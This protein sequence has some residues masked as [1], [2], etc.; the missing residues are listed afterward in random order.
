MLA[1]G[2]HCG[3]AAAGKR[4]LVLALA[5][6]KT[7]RWSQ[8]SGQST[9][10]ARTGCREQTTL[11]RTF[12][13]D[14]LV[15]QGL[16]KAE[17]MRIDVIGPISSAPRETARHGDQ[18][19]SCNLPNSLFSQGTQLSHDTRLDLTD[20]WSTSHVR[21]AEHLHIHSDGARLN[22]PLSWLCQ[23]R[24]VLAIYLRKQKRA[25][26]SRHS[27]VLSDIL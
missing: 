3:T 11:T 16:V 18:C 22:R 6:L 5:P 17:A 4:P 8:S 27:L 15:E 12:V 24:H 25:A 10:V 20:T 7:C 2:R 26:P 9:D 14:A 19:S 13:E 21:T 1:Y 23:N